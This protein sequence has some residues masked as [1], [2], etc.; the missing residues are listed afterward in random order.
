M[1]L[2]VGLGNPTEQYAHTRHNV[3]FDCID[4]L[5]AE[6]S[7]KI[8]RSLH[9]SYYGKGMIGKEKV[10]LAKPR[11][12]MNLSGQ[13]VQALMHFYKIEKDHLIVIYDDSDLD[14][15]RLRIRKSGSAGGHNGMKDIIRMTG[16]QD[17]TR[18]RI[19]I[20]HC[21]GEMDM[22][23]FVLGHPSGEERTLL[24]DAFSRAAA[25]A[26]DIVENGPD[27]AMNRF[28]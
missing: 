12:F 6:L 10:I 11:T 5:A 8:N 26:I 23:D 7:V 20:G 17:F 25:A 9:K 19:G 24:D 21:P 13:A 14:T 18:I 27:H 16:T 15:G 3:G 28:N 22:A 2:I 1:Y 4:L